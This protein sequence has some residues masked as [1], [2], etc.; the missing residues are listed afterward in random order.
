MAYFPDL[1]PFGYLRREPDTLNVGWLDDA[2]PYPT[3]D[4]PQGF[5]E[6]LMA[7][8]K[9]S[10]NPTFGMHTC[11]ICKEATCTNEIR[12]FGAG[13]TVYAAPTMIYHYVLD[14]GYRPPDAF[15]AAL[16][17]SPLPGSAEYLLRARAYPWGEC[18]ARCYARRAQPGD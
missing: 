6:R 7:F 3:G 10:V 18:I 12:V 11:E 9:M 1:S 14:H 2:H 13:A 4:V 17:S 15:I 8:L 16:F 5:A